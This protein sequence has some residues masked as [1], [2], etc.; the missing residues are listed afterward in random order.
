MTE[1]TAGYRSPL[2]NPEEVCP[3]C[4]GTDIYVRWRANTHDCT[5]NAICKRQ[6]RGEPE[7]CTYEHMHWSCRRCQYEELR[8]PLDGPAR[9]EP[10]RVRVYPSRPTG[11]A[12]RAH[13]DRDAS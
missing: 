11:A 13:I 9:V 1:Q 8:E 10:D 3:K 2:Y 5:Y 6:W 4:L 12:M 7:C